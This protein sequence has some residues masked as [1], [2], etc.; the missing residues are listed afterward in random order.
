MSTRVNQMQNNDDPDCAKPLRE[1]THRFGLVSFDSGI[2]HPAV[3]LA[4][5]EALKPTG[6]HHNFGRQTERTPTSKLTVDAGPGS[7]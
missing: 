3:Q 6:K 7:E 2:A 1:Q 5:S 4:G